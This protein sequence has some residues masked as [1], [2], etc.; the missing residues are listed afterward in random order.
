[1]FKRHG[2]EVF[3]LPL[4]RYNKE[5]IETELIDKIRLVEATHF[6]KNQLEAEGFIN[7]FKRSLSFEPIPLT[8]FHNQVVHTDGNSTYLDDK[9]FIAN[10]RATVSLIKIN[11][12]KD[13]K[14]R[15]KK[16]SEL[17]KMNVAINA[18]LFNDNSEVFKMTAPAVSIL[19]ASPNSRY[20]VPLTDTHIT[21]AN[22]VFESITKLSSPRPNPDF[23]SAYVRDLS[24]IDFF[25]R[26]ETV[27]LISNDISLKNKL[28]VSPIWSTSA[29][30]LLREL[31][32]YLD[33]FKSR[34][35]VD[36][37]TNPRSLGIK[38]GKLSQTMAN[39]DIPTVRD[40][41]FSKG[42]KRDGV[43]LEH[44]VVINQTITPT[45]KQTDAI[46]TALIDVDAAYS[47]LTEE[48]KALS[49]TVEVGKYFFLDVKLLIE[50]FLNLIVDLGE[51]T[52]DLKVDDMNISSSD[53][54]V[55]LLRKFAVWHMAI[56]RRYN[57]RGANKLS[58][59]SQ[60]NCTVA[61][62]LTDPASFVDDRLITINRNTREMKIEHLSTSEDILGQDSFPFENSMGKV[63]SRLASDVIFG[64][65]Y[66]KP[67]SV[68]TIDP[69]LLRSKN[70]E[71]IE[72][73][74]YS[75][76]S[77]FSM[78]DRLDPRIGIISY[79][80]YGPK[81]GAEVYIGY[82][83]D[84]LPFNGSFIGLALDD[85]VDYLVKIASYFASLLVQSIPKYVVGNIY[86]Y[87]QSSNQLNVWKD[88]Y[89]FATHSELHY[90]GKDIVS[91]TI[92]NLKVKFTKLTD[93]VAM[94]DDLEE[95]VSNEVQ[96]AL[97]AFKN[98]RE[99]L[100]N[101]EYSK[102]EQMLWSKCSVASVERNARTDEIMLEL[103]GNYLYFKLVDNEEII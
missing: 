28:A 84:G 98:L 49:Y 32:K 54:L 99:F 25:N 60:C 19:L 29:I 10:P 102:L 70:W 97:F 11:N 14:D 47:S 87:Q 37:L 58:S 57:S 1:M 39:F 86:S 67:V 100:S 90:V 72:I 73:Q 24:T 7:S 103:P 62:K 46:I 22:R 93:K 92:L 40:S 85:E 50:D 83:I 38:V 88:K 42:A 16:Q 68:Q 91:R 52:T 27:H 77:G 63:L 43:A 6:D 82:M 35:K 45:G 96:R 23:N 3:K 17:T 48:D 26:E 44:V 89:H 55:T 20:F 76:V 13:K 101:S 81:P 59:R 56:L 74:K 34:I 75:A 12:L 61:V 21:A 15:D 53:D 95:F 51:R 4:L 33:L 65:S 18:F 41:T 66:P 31:N 5:A 94:N 64:T 79:P 78:L 2:N 9:Y 8:E 69:K 36:K 80:I 71:F 30:R